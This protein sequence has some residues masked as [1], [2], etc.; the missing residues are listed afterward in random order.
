MATEEDSKLQELQSFDPE[1]LARVEQLGESF[2]F[3]EAVPAARDLVSFY[4]AFSLPRLHYLPEAQRRVL[5]EKASGVLTLFSEMQSFD[6]SRDHNATKTRIN[7]M[8]H[9]KTLLREAHQL[10]SWAAYVIARDEARSI[11][12]LVSRGEAANT[13]VQ[14]KQQELDRLIEAGREV[15][16]E[17]SVAAQSRYFASSAIGHEK[18]ATRWT[19][20]ASLFGSALS[21]ATHSRTGKNTTKLTRLIRKPPQRNILVENVRILIYCTTVH[22]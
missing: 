18:R 4:R 20:C 1:A 15:T 9:M 2:N 12:D 5:G 10:H 3:S 16:G 8:E 21:S 22:S 19:W 11:D 13:R 14:A 7:Y 6:P 17:A